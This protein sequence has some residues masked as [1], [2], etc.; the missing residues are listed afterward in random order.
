MAK[1]IKAKLKFN[2]PGGGAT[3]APPVGSV[4][5][6]QGVSAMDFCKQFNAATADRRGQTCPVK[7]TVYTDRTFD[8]EIKTPPVSELLRKHAGIAKG[9]NNPGTQTA[10]KISRSAI[11]EI[12]K[13]KMVD[14][15]A[16]TVEA[17]C[18]IV[19]G[20]ARSMG[21]EVE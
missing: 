20:S 21:L 10:G 15:N 6:P 9:A 1:Q 7:L 14:L 13:V 18:A 19:A 5:G 2:V 11:E 12:A 17:A 16:H 3:P 8:F 4:L